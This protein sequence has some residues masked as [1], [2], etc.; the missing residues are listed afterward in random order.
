MLYVGRHLLS[1][2]LLTL[3]VMVIVTLWLLHNDFSPQAAQQST[4]NKPAL[5]TVSGRVIYHDSEQPVRRVTVVLRNLTNLGPEQHTAFTNARGEFRIEGV[6]EGRYFIGVNGRGVVSTDSFIEIGD[7]RE[8]R[9]D[10]NDLR[11]YFE[12]IEIDGRTSKQVVIRAHRGG[13]ISGKVSYANGDPAID[14]PITILR[15]KGDKYAVFFTN[16]NTMQMVL[17]TDDR[18]VFRVSGLPIGEYIVGATPVIEH[19]ELVKDSTLE[20]NMIGSSLSMTFHPSTMLPTQAPPISIKAGEEKT[21]IDITLADQ[22]SHIV[23]GVVRRRDNR[24]PVPRARVRIIRKET[25][26]TIGRAFW[27]YSEGMPGVGTDDQ[28]RWRLREVPDGRYI[29]FVE[30]S[31]DGLPS[32]QNTF[33]I[34]RQEIEVSGRNIDNLMI[35]LGNGATVSGTVVVESGAVPAGIYVGLKQEGFQSFEPSA[36]VQR[37]GAFVIPGVSPGKAYFFINPGEGAER[38]YLKSITWNGK[39]VLRESLEIGAD[40]KIEDVRIV[41]SRQVA[42]LTIRV[43]SIFGAPVENVSLALVPSDPARW[44]RWEAQLYCTT[45]AQGKCTVVGAPLEYL[46]FILPRGV[47]SA[48]LEKDEIEGG[49]ATARR[50]SLR[51]AERRSFEIVLPR[52]K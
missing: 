28:G 14:H 36:I 30:P 3:T 50:V 25:Y 39:D 45:D 20:A 23:A 32:E 22:Q 52:E 34:K 19:G 37:T 33:P 8:T 26:E 43:L 46:V 16:S 51:P 42:T 48:T 38:L 4:E 10:R 47:Q 9:Y 12:E 1:I 21:G 11:Q 29:I 13:I 31:D 49:A 24:R 18:G 5:S 41:L 44:Q 35:E 27:P 40:E 17:L 6:P 7:Y 15:R 2:L